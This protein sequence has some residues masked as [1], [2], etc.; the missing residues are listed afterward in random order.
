MSVMKF[1]EYVATNL[2]D[3]VERSSQDSLIN[4][5]ENYENLREIIAEIDRLTNNT[6]TTQVDDI[7]YVVLLT[8]YIIISITF[9]ANLIMV[10]I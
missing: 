2:Q 8:L 10:P 9:I 6:T 3:F 4:F 7:T 1:L 5:Y